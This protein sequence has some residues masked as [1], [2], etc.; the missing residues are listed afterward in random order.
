[1][2]ELAD[3]FLVSDQTGYNWINDANISDENNV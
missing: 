1:M 3:C 2:I